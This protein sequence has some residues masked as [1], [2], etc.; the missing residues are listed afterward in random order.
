VSRKPPP[1]RRAGPFG[2]D[3]VLAELRHLVDEAVAGRGHLMLLAGEAGI[4]KTTMLTAAA[5]YAESR[6]AR[7]AWGWGWPGEGAPGYWP[8]IQVMRMF[9]LD[10]PWPGEESRSTAGDAAASDRF[11]LFDEVTSLLLAESRIQPMLVLLD[12]LQWADQPSQLLLD[13]LA[14]RLPA[15]A[16]AVVG[17]Y[18]DVAPAPG[19]AL[20]A[21]AARTAVLPL[22]GLGLDAVTDLVADAVG[23]R[24]AAELAA[25]VHRRSGGNPFFVQQVSWL[26][27]SGQ[28]GIPPGVQEALELRFAALPATVA[29]TLRAAAV[30]GPR[31]SAELVARVAGE[32]PEAVTEALATAV[33]ARVLSRDAP[34]GYRF[35]HDL[36]REYAYGQLP[37]ADR[38]RLHLR[39]GQALETARERPD[40]EASLAELARHFVHADPAS[41]QARRYSVM[42]AREAAARLAYEEAVRHWERAVAAGPELAS[43]E[44]ASAEPSST[45]S[46]SPGP[47]GQVEILLELADA[48]R[49]AGQGQEA[50]QAYLRAAELARGDHPPRPP[51]EGMA[52][53][54]PDP[55]GLA[56]AALGLHAIGTRAWWPPDQVVALL[57][58]A[59]GALGTARGDGAL[60]PAPGDGPLR[61]RVMASLARALAWHG[62]D[63]ARARSLAAEAVAAARAD[64]DPLTVASCLLA[65]HHAIWAAGNARDRLRIATE[66]AG[67]GD[68]AGDQEMLLEGRLLAATD[69]LELGDPAFRAELGEF[70]RLAEASRQPRFR[71]AALVRRGA[72]ALLEGRLAEA[73]RLI[74]QAEML[75]TECGEPG[76]RDVRYDQGW[77]LLTAQGRLG[78]L[79]GALPQ[80]FPDPQ[81]PQARGS[82][83]LVLLAAGARSEAAEAV[84]PLLNAGSETIPPGR[85]RL[86][87]LTY[88]AE[89]MAAFGVGPAAEQLYAALLP[90]EDETVV[91]GAAV[92]FKGAVAYYLGLLAAVLGRSA[93]AA[94]HL[95]RSV[96]IHDRL[97]AAAWSLR[98]KY[99]LARVLLGE[100]QNATEPRNAAEPRNPAEPR[101]AAEPQNPAEPRNLGLPGEPERRAAALAALAEVAGAARSLGLAQLARDA[102]AAR[103]AAG[104]VPVTEGVFARDGAMWT[105]AYGGMTVRMRD[106]K[107]LADLAA[108]LAAPG[109]EIPAA[110]LIAAAGAGLVGLA[111]LRLG[112][113][114]VLDATARRQIRTR[115]ADLGEDIAEAQSWNDPERAARARA[116]RDALLRE[117][118]AAAGP[119]G[120]VRLLGDQSERARKAVTAR[121]RDIIG[122]IERVHPALG[123]HLRE[124]VTTGTRCTYS[125]RV[126]VSWRL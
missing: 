61:L 111:D 6:G 109:R 71:Y 103:F 9:G 19:P 51:R 76:V 90:F 74:G 56:R 31:F 64:G 117:L 45:V 115:L 43:A 11:R 106:A 118:A 94:S 122:R 8:W 48:R 126:P 91:S 23:D 96:A 70:L 66:V 26:L 34:G 52:R 50:A 5:G 112:A 72:L 20:A 55:A 49:R 42:A 121:I 36:F 110:G 14:R 12:D 65:Q 88:A 33:R 16:V 24:R 85:L 101:N 7:V 99:Q 44:P 4:G 124:S 114:E 80:M 120:Q 75:G 108:L 116:E 98:S 53:A 28:D 125:P 41:A 62:L 18:R 89:L 97:G 100:P 59:L 40:Q 27:R 37:A 35:T 86:V 46:A 77:D 54:G 15:G 2:R 79:G 84:A 38:A 22:T 107:G 58:E 47:P 82:R 104:Q 32:Q 93:A 95:E 1:P 69:R 68:Q 39:A 10:I 29:A 60:P 73:E 102:E 67:L 78:E 83:A 17:S 21:L 113:D 3:D 87:S 81:S 57:S 30:T 25:G 119:A 105:L 13:F 63:L 92:T 123:A